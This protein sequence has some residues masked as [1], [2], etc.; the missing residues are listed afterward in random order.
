MKLQ[1]ALLCLF[2]SMVLNNNM[3]AANKAIKEHPQ[4][5]VGWTRSARPLWLRYAGKK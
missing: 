4:R 2:Q 5:A 1:K 3:T